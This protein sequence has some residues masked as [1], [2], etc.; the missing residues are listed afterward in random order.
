MR[1]FATVRVRAN[2]PGEAQRVGIGGG[3]LAGLLATRALSELGWDVTIYERDAL[4]DVPELRKSV[5]QAA[6]PHVTCLQTALLGELLRESPSDPSTACPV[7]ERQA[8]GPS[9]AETAEP[10]QL[11]GHAAVSRTVRSS[12]AGTQSFSGQDAAGLRHELEADHQ[13]SGSTGIP[14]LVDC[15]LGFD[16]DRYTQLPEAFHPRR[17]VDWRT[18]DEVH[19]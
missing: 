4:P 11:A 14:A 3:S 7:C 2:L 13:R 15:R 19:E 18:G 6:H 8:T 12:R 5:P 17:D 1:W 9:S 16:V 10:C